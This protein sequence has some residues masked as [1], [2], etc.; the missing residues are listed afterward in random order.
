MIMR[1]ASGSTVEFPEGRLPVLTI[2]GLTLTQGITVAAHL[3]DD[4]EAKVIAGL[5][6]QQR[7][8]MARFIAANEK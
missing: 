8:L 3:Y 1:P 6:K 7:A 5:L 2:S 4:Y